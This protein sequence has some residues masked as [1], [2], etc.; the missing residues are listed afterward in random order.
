MILYYN[1][2]TIV[3]LVNTIH[4]YTDRDICAF[5]HLADRNVH[6]E[7]QKLRKKELVCFSQWN[8]N[9]DDET[10]VTSQ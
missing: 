6:S 3:R 1:I 9:N 10:G 4:T 5:V 8:V 7:A 2:C